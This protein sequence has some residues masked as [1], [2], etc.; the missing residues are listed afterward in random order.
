MKLNQGIL[1]TFDYNQDNTWV[2]MELARKVSK[3]DFKR[4]TGFSFED[5]SAAVNTYG[6]DVHPRQYAHK[7]DVDKNVVAAMWEDEFVYGIFDYIGNY[8]IPVG[9][10]M[11]LSS[12]GIVKRGGKDTIVLIDFGMTQGVSTSYYA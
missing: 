7:A 10:L 11:R 1:R 9:D 3:G 6:L 5:Y 12:Y 2:E 8:D 4:I